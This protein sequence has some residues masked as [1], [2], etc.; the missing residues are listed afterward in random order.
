LLKLKDVPQE[1]MGEVVRIAS[2]MYDKEHQEKRERSS[3]VAAAEE[4]GI[5]E[6]YLERAAK[7]LQEKRIAEA[8][9]RQEKRRR[10]LIGGGIAAAAVAIGLAVVRPVPP[11]AALSLTPQTTQAIV[12]SNPGSDVVVTPSGNGWLLNVRQFVPQN[13]RYS[14]NADIKLPTAV[15]RGHNNVSLA[16]TPNRGNIPKVRIFFEGGT[17]NQRWKGPDVSL[18]G[19]SAQVNVPLN[20]FIRQT[21]PSSG[22]EWRDVGKGKPTGADTLS[23]KTGY[24]INPPDVSGEIGIDNVQVK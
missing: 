20:D 22:A 15:Q 7:E 11:A 14:G 17:P 23:I 4:L 12:T 2:E 1:Q 18:T 21:R 19:G 10:F 9:L 13:G 3:T 6:E 16:L 24:P 5:P 8:R